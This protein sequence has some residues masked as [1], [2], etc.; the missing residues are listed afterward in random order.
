VL[1]F[2]VTHDVQVVSTF[3]SFLPVILRSFISMW[4][5]ITRI[6]TTDPHEQTYVTT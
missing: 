4:L 3:V 6:I 5:Y 2:Q 1:E